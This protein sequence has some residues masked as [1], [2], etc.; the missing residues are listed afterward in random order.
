MR[1][2][3]FRVRL[4]SRGLRWSQN[5]WSIVGQMRSAVVTKLL[6]DLLLPQILIAKC[7]P[8]HD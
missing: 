5:L 3:L 4:F 6:R 8:R 2:I 7:R 1:K